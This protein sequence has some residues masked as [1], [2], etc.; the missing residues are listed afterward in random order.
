MDFF[1]FFFCKMRKMSEVSGHLFHEIFYKQS[2]VE[3]ITHTVE[4][5]EIYSHAFWQK[6]REING[7][8]K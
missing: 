7:F 5:A 8:T 6:F 1:F 3:K 2:R 4:I